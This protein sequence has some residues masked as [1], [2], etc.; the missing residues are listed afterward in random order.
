[1]GTGARI[2]SMNA[3]LLGLALLPAPEAPVERIGLG[4]CLHQDRPQPVWEGLLAAKPDTFVWLGDNIYASRPEESNKPVQ[5]AKL[6]ARPEFQR[7]MATARNLAIWDDHDFGKN[8]GGSEWEGKEQAQREFNDFWRTP[9]DSPRRK[10]PG[11][12][13]SVTLGPAGRRVQFVLVDTRT[14]RSPL[15]R[16]TN[17]DGSYNAYLPTQRGTLLGDEQ[18]RWLEERLR[19]PADLRIIASSIQVV[20]EDHMFEKWANLPNERTRL[21]ELIGKTGA[22]GVVFVSGDRH[23]A[24]VSMLPQSAAG[25]PLYDLTASALNMSRY[26]WRAQEPNRWRVATMNVGDNFGMLML[27]WKARTVS[28]QIRDVRNEIVIN[29]TV[30][31][32]VLRRRG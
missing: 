24:E 19:E 6:A 21:F 25:Y 2:G 16:E 27:D 9:A 4:S 7:L 29:Q 30:S 22:N 23:L 10:R 26:E 13:D 1:M 17:V 15:N 32:D 8:D 12:Y 31:M 5:Y 20:P 18:W 11:I 14:F 3:L 28:L